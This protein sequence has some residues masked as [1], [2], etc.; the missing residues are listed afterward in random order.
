[1]NIKDDTQLDNYN[2]LHVII[3][4]RNAKKDKIIP[5]TGSCRPRQRNPRNSFNKRRLPSA[6]LADDGN[7]GNVDVDLDTVT[8]NEL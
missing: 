6:L 4:S 5:S 2:K 7:L 1:V 8:A 3:H